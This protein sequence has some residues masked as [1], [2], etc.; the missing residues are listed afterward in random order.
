MISLNKTS[1]HSV[2]LR[3]AVVAIITVGTALSFFA[4]SIT[5]QKRRPARHGSICGDPT[6]ACKTRVEFQPYQLRFRLPANAV[7][8]DSELF[9]AIILKSMRA[10]DDNCDVFIP[11]NE[12]LAA[13][14]MFPAN[15]VFS[16]RCSEPGDLSYTN[17]NS[18]R[19]MAV[20][21]GMT[22][23]DANRMLAAARATGKFP[24]A[25]IRRMR[26]VFNGT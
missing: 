23:V 26:A 17:T 4:G 6:A 1:M 7:I 19:F 13:Q 11:E 2:R 20:Y 8:W 10:P 15:K 14:A 22:L 18:N 3:I 16:S 9:Y 24:G 25:N 21:A 12:R 5:A